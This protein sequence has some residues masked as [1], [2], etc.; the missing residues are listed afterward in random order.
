MED[1][2]ARTVTL[3]FAG[4]VSRACRMWGPRFPVAWE[5]GGGYV[6]GWVGGWVGGRG[7][8]KGWG[9]VMVG[10][11]HQRGRRS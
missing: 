4:E 8:G 2:R 11:I 6:S 9:G 5:G 3:K 7:L 10:N 1:V